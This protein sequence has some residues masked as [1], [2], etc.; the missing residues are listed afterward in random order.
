[1]ELWRWDYE[2]GIMDMESWY[3]WIWD[4]GYG[5]LDMGLCIWEYRYIWCFNMEWN[6]CYADGM[7]MGLWTWDYGYGI[8]AWIWDHSM[9][10]GLWIRYMGI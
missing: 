1:M 4:Y 2:Y 6:G 7:G 10:I 9:D 8:I 5:I 3:V